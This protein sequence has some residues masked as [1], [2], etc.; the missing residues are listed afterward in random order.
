MDPIGTKVDDILLMTT[1]RVHFDIFCSKES[2]TVFVTKGNSLKLADIKMRL[3]LPN[4][5]PIIVIFPLENR[6]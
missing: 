4:T 1:R 2:E 3:D 6:L 5:L